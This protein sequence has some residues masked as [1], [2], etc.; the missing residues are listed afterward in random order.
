MNSLIKLAVT[1]GI[2]YY[3]FSL[4]SAMPAQ[5]QSQTFSQCVLSLYRGP[6][7]ARDAATNC[8]DVFK[9]KP[10]NE[11]FTTCVEALYEGPYS[12][13]DSNNYCKQASANA[14]QP[15]Q[16]PERPPYPYPYPPYPYPPYPQQSGGNPQAV[17]NCVK[18]LMYER[19]AV[20]T[21]GGSCARLNSPEE[22]ANNN[23]G[24]WQWQTVR[25]SISESAA[26]Q[27]CQGAT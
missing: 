15:E 26:A 16:Q 22:N 10:V 21:R 19:K 8:L 3:G 2:S 23:F 1:M 25:T 24:G 11:E 18:K 5:A 17:A 12:R 20:C 13:N 7:S 27:A 9:D 6:Y 4:L 14:R